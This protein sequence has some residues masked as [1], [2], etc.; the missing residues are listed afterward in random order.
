MRSAD[1]PNDE[2]GRKYVVSVNFHSGLRKYL[3]CAIV[4]EEQ[5]FP[6]EVVLTKH[7]E[8]DDQKQ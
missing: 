1:I 4:I 6:L 8:Q 7:H 5:H 3:F 2:I